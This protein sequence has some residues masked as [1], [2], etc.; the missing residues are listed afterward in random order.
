MLAAKISSNNQSQGYDVAV[1]FGYKIDRMAPQMQVSDA[2]QSYAHRNATTY[3]TSPDTQVFAG[4]PNWH[5]L[6]NV[7]G[8]FGPSRDPY[9]NIQD[10]PYSE[11]N[12]YIGGPYRADCLE[13]SKPEPAYEIAPQFDLPARWTALAPSGQYLARLEHVREVL[14]EQ[15]RVEADS[16]TVVVAELRR[17]L[18]RVI[19]LAKIETLVVER[20][21]ELFKPYG[22]FCSQRP[23]TFGSPLP[24]ESLG[25]CPYLIA[26]TVHISA[27]PSP[28]AQRL[29]ALFYYTQ[30][31]LILRTLS[32]ER[33]KRRKRHFFHRLNLVRKLVH[34]SR[35][36]FCGVAWSRRLWHLL[37]GSHPPKAGGPAVCPAFGCA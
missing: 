35:R 17:S 22:T 3:W 14:K 15:P 28:I 24:S 29:D 1:E 5:H 19:Q 36:S 11:D 10:Y 8:W 9:G 6:G 25:P 30:P 26:D 20:R 21:P 31:Q 2:I 13:S 32:A 4:V 7:T 27:A 23:H 33:K 16:L 12:E 18:N 34:R 37:H